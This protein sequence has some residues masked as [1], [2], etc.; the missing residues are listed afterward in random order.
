[1]KRGKTCESVDMKKTFNSLLNTLFIIFESFFPI[2]TTILKAKNNGFIT[3]GIK[4]SS[5]HNLYMLS[6][7]KA[8]V[9]Y[10]KMFTDSIV[11]Y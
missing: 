2:Q 3:R 1:V 11:P 7:G 8:I 5:K 10:L 6:T 9:H 4:I